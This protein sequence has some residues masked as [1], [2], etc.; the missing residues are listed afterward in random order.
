MTPVFGDSVVYIKDAKPLNAL[1]VK[2]QDDL[3]TLIYIDPS[4]ESAVSQGN[5]NRIASVAIGVKP[6]APGAK[7]GW[8]DLISAPEQLDEAQGPVTPSDPESPHAL[9]IETKTYSDGSSATGVA[10]LP[11]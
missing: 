5:L 11:D 1:V 8:Q 6:L 9:T 4:N 7:F 2:S 3:L 10:P